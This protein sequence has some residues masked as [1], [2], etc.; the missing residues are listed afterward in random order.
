MATLLPPQLLHNQSTRNWFARIEE[1]VAA[2]N[3]KPGVALLALSVFYLLLVVPI[4]LIKLLWADEFI[5]YYIAKLNSVGGI[6]SALSRGAD[7]NPPLSHLL[8]M[9][10]MRLFG[11]SAFAVRIPAI[12][13]VLVGVICVFL[14]LRRRLPVVFAAAGT[15]LFLSTAALNYAYES[16]SYALILGFSMLSLLLWSEAVDGNHERAATIGLAIT[17]GAGIASNYFCVLAFFPIAAGE[18]IR[19]LRHRKIE[20]RIWTALAI[21][22]LPFLFFLP[23]INHS[24][25]QFGPHAWNKPKLDVI[26]DSYT[27]MV[28]VVLAPAL[29]ILGIGIIHFLYQRR[30][31]RETRPP[32]LPRHEMVAV[33]VMMMYPMLGYALAVARAGMI[34]PRFVLPVCWG[35]AIATVVAFYRMFSRNAVAAAAL[36]LVFASW[37]IARDGFCAYDYFEQR[38]AFYRVL[39]NMPPANAIVVADSLLVQPL[40]HYAPPQVAARIVFPLD[41]TLIERYKREDSLEQ[42][43]WAGRGIFPVP[44]VS[45][46]QL[47]ETYPNYVVVAANGNWLL[48]KFEVDGAPAPR[49]PIATNSRDIGGFTPL[50]HGETYFFEV[51]NTPPA[52]EQYAQKANSD[53]NWSRENHRV[54]GRGMQQ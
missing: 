26:A 1:A 31:T 49:L 12:I 19:D 13:T 33:F 6:W 24:I 3:Q 41:F 34:S 54:A 21:G 52:D 25:A 22:G 50:S 35:F 9:W 11:D 5:T 40:Y 20:W 14:F 8:V 45:M 30:E 44:I 28:E 48:Q 47:Q 16:R 29:A 53:T 2:I 4:A 17:L 15:C 18:L 51:G 36:L 32:V 46:E 42:N 10:S 39:N 38:V 43:Y 23:L 37:A 7:P 27:E